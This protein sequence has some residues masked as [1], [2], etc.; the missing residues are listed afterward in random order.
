MAVRPFE[1]IVL[2]ESR[3]VMGEAKTYYLSHQ[4]EPICGDM[5]I[6]YL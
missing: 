1:I 3:K 2:L 4:S 5:Q 6:T